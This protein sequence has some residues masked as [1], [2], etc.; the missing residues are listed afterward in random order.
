MDGDMARRI[1]L[2]PSK[3]G[4]SKSSPP[5]PPRHDHD[6]GMMGSDPYT[7]FPPEAVEVRF[8]CP[9]VVQICSFL[10][11]VFCFFLQDAWSREP[12]TRSEPESDMGSLRQME[13]GYIPQGT[14]F[15]PPSFQPKN[16]QPSATSRR[17]SSSEHGA[18][19]FYIPQG[20]SFPPPNT[21][22]GD[23]ED[24]SRHEQ[25][26][27]EAAFLSDAVVRESIQFLKREVISAADE[28]GQEIVRAEAERLR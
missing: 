2:T 18:D 16:V 11:R 21:F 25:T 4:S 12:L 26:R 13:M 15:P 27:S 6:F 24:E 9:N 14:S 22:E 7:A 1:S 8:G 28:A 19:K 20:D 5:L 23:F 3:V 10:T 17:N